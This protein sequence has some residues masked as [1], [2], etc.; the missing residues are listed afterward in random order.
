[1]RII[2]TIL[3]ALLV[4]SSYADS[5]DDRLTRLEQRLSSK[6]YMDMWQLLD[7]LRNEMRNLR[8]EIEQQSFELQKAQQQQKK[9]NLDLEQRLQQVEKSAVAPSIINQNRL[10]TSDQQLVGDSVD[11]SQADQSLDP[12]DTSMVDP[13]TISAD[14]DKALQSLREGQ[15]EEAAQQF[16]QII[17]LYPNSEL[18]DNAQ[19]WLAETKYINRDFDTATAMFQRVVSQYPNSSKVPDAL[20]KIAFIKLELNQINEGKKQ[21]TAL[22]ERYPQSSA[23]KLAQQRLDNIH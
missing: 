18:A 8:G 7:Q 12:N 16:K 20:L 1:M 19:Y 4:T 21:L 3:L 22:I 23:A 14:Y 2:T 9:M 6:A 15:Y 13:Q 10:E 11:L 5:D 17:T